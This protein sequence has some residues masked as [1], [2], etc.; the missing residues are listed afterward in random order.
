MQRRAAAAYVALFLVLGL[1]A[2]GFMQVGMAKPTVDLQ[3]QAYGNGSTLT[4][5][6]TT[7]TVENVGLEGGGG[8]GHG[9]GGG[10]THVAT[11]T[12]TDQDNEASESISHGST[13]TSNGLEW[14]VTTANGSDVSEATLTA[15][16]NVTAALKADDRLEN[17]TIT[18]DGEEHVVYKEDG[19]IE[20]VTEYLGPNPTQTVS[21][22][23]A[24]SYEVEGETIDATVAD[25]TADGITLEYSNP[26]DREAELAE[27]ANVTLQGEDYFAHFPADH[28]VQILKTSQRYGTYQAQLDVISDWEQR[29]AGLWGITILSLLAVVIMLPSAYMPDRG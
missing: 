13:L 11:L 26:V 18:V 28:E 16:H 19:R 4:V 6:G 3:G 20:P 2:Y 12:W 24:I 27:G 5:G 22:G 21:T 17:E 29:R 8:G 10:A 25:V 1:G 15:S 23:D 14:T 7:Y 9:G